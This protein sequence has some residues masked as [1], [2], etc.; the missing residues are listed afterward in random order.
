M[1]IKVY[2]YVLFQLLIDQ[3]ELVRELD[4]VRGVCVCGGV[5]GRLAPQSELFTIHLFVLYYYFFFCIHIKPSKIESS[6]GICCPSVKLTKRKGGK[7]HPYIHIIAPLVHLAWG[8]TVGGCRA[9]VQRTFILT[10]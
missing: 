5:G 3:G 10:C 1:C 4:A 8:H 2:I 7:T 6:S 9:P